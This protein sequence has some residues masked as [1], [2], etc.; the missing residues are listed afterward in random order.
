V[1]IRGKMKDADWLTNNTCTKVS[2]ENL[3]EETTREKKTK[4]DANFMHIPSQ[5]SFII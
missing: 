4:T 2:L 5:N 3:E 1:C